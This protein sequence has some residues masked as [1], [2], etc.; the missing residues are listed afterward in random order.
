MKIV[1]GSIGVAVVYA[2]LVLTTGCESPNGTQNNTGTGALMG[3]ALGAVIGAVADRSHPGTGALIGA[4]IGAASGAIAGHIMDQINAQQ[5]AQ[6]QQQSP[7]TL[8]TIQH[9]DAVIQ[10]QQAQSRTQPGQTSPSETTE[11]PT[12]LTVDDIKALSAAGVKKD[13]IIQEI[14]DSKAVYSPTDIVAA[15]EASPRVDPSVIEF[16]KSHAG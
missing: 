12:P 11:A 9:N 2:V 15:Q 4:A 7:Q 16:M 6:L 13:V 14:G 5:R 8:Q 3:G 1:H 10:H